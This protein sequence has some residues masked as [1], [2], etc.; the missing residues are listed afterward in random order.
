MSVFDDIRTTLETAIDAMTVVG[1]FNFDYDNVNEYR[2]ASKSY[3][4][5]L[6]TFPDEIAREVDGN[7]IDSYSTDVIVN[8]DVTVNATPADTNTALE[9]V[10]EDFKRLMGEQHNSLQTQGMIVAHFIDSVKRFTLV[11][12]RPGAIIINFNVFYRV[13]ESNPAITI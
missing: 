2:P 4:N 12:A 8:F 3:P 11:R 1:G 7:M 10:L 5:V 13:R 6:V 9:N